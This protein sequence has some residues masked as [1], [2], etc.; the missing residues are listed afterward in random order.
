M[1][2]KCEICGARGNIQ[3]HH[4][5]Y[6]PEIIQLLCV[7]CHE[8]VHNHGVGK[9]P[10]WTPLF[11]WLKTDAETLFKEGATNNEVANACGISYPTAS[12][13][14]KKLGLAVKKYLN[15]KGNRGIRKPLVTH[16][17]DEVV[18]VPS[19]RRVILPIAFCEKKAIKENVWY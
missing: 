4:I 19:S 9:A 18:R 5:S 10:G 8:A 16:I 7:D 6:E 12:H 1:T 2:E 11:K 17:G 13:W 15:Q 3:K 14:R